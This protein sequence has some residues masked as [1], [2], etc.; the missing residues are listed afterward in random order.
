MP[1]VVE[2]VVEDRERRG[3][4][5]VQ[6]V[7]DE[8]AALALPDDGEQAQHGLGDHEVRGGVGARVPAAGQQP[9]HDRSVAAE[10]VRVGQQAGPGQQEQGLDQRPVR[11][12]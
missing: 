10:F 1:D 11:D 12:G 2:E 6:V 5:V 8:Q 7:E 9:G 4:G 3:V